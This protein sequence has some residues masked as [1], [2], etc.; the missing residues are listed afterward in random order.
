VIASLTALPTVFS[1]GLQRQFAY[2]WNYL[3]RALFSAM[4]LLVSWVFWGAVFHGKETVGPY[5]LASLLTYYAVLLVVESVSSPA[6]DDF[7]I[8]REIR[9][10][11]L[12]SILLRPLPYGLYRGTLFLAGRCAYLVAALIPV[13][14]CFYLLSQVV[15][16]QLGTLDLARGIPAL[17]GSA[18]LQFSL[19]LCL[20]FT[21]F[22]LLDIS[23]LIFLVYSME[24]LAGGH[25]FPLN[26]LPPSLFQIAQLLPF[27]YEY[28]FPAASL[29]GSLSHSAWQFGLAMQLGWALVFL[30]LAHLLWKAGLRKYTAA[31]G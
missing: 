22:W 18:L 5:T 31:G 27:A 24:F 10:G 19:T 2:R 14:L 17:L 23:A 13:A 6:D 21:S 8:S 15:S 9:E 4:P 25:V 30:I 26:L 3:L 7:Q 20:S 12:N 16:L 28:W 29:C 11:T 1:I